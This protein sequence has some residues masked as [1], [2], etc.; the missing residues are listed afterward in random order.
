MRVSPVTLKERAQRE[1][2]RWRRGLSADERQ[3]LRTAREEGRL[4][5]VGLLVDDACELETWRDELREYV[6]NHEDLVFHLEERT[7]HICRAHPVA[8]AVVA[9]GVVPAGVTCG[10]RTC[11]FASARP[12]QLVAVARSTRRSDLEPR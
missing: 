11:P 12:M 10:N 7:W 5:L 4:V 1:L 2:V 3:Q 9:T 8:H 6:Q